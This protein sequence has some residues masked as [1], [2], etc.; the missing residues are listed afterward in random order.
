MLSPLL[1]SI[2]F[3]VVLLIALQRFNINADILADLVHLDESPK[4]MGLN[5]ALDV[6][7]RAV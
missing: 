7:M 2:F 4:G 3:A 6:V 5:N 1:F